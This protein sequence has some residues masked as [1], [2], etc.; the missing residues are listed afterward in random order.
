MD[1]KAKRDIDEFL[2]VVDQGIPADGELYPD[3]VGW[4]VYRLEP[5]GMTVVACRDCRQ[6][7]LIPSIP[8]VPRLVWTCPGCDRP[9]TLQ[10]PP[11]VWVTGSR[12]SIV[13][14]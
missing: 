5:T 1:R 12:P 9:W 11:I 7:G 10:P 14:A 8:R 4:A 6:V 3:E 2:D 13:R